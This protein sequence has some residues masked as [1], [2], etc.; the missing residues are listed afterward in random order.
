MPLAIY[1][2]AAWT[3]NGGL[4]P[5]SQALVTVRSESTGGLASLFEDRDG[6]SGLDNPFNADSQGRFEFYVTGGAYRVEVESDGFT[7]ELR[8]QAVG[9]SAERDV[10]TGADEVP[11]NAALPCSVS[12][13]GLSDH[14]APE[15]KE[16]LA[17]LDRLESALGIDTEGPAGADVLAAVGRGAIVESDTNANGSYVRWENGEQVCWAIFEFS[18]TEDGSDTGPQSQAL[19]ADFVNNSSIHQY[20]LATDGS[21]GVEGASVGGYG[22][23]GEIQFNSRFRFRAFV[24]NI[25]S[26]DLY[27]VFATAWGFWK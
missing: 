27:G 19:P 2:S 14:K 25:S 23:G 3:A 5:A 11:D 18:E 9:T 16:L 6:N 1:T 15:G 24:P 13:G 4:S 8:H 17:R 22:S 7:Q 12:V 26:D 20:S 21:S 10:G